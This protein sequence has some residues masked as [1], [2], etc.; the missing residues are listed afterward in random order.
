M[1]SL[2]ELLLDWFSQVFTY[3]WGLVGYVASEVWLW[4]IKYLGI[5]YNYLHD[6]LPPG[7]QEFMSTWPFSS[8]IME[9]GDKVDWFIPWKICLGIWVFSTAVCIIIRTTRWA[10]GTVKVF[11]WGLDA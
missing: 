2:I 1:F 7:V 3:L 11:G 8:T 9:Y 10:L 6:L 4:S 5:A